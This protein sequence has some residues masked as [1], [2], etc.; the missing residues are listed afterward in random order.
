MQNMNQISLD[1]YQTLG[2]AV[3]VLFLGAFLKKR[4]KFLETFCI[5]SPVVGGLIFAIVSCILY[6]TGILEI[7]FDETLK[8]VCMVI[9]FTS[10]GFQANLKVLKSGGLS[11][12][13]F[14]VCV[15]VLII[16]QNLVSVGL[17]KLVGVSPL[18][19][20]STG[21][22]PMVGGHGTAGAFG[23]VLEDF[24]NLGCVNTLYS[25][26]NIRIGSR[27]TYGRTYWQTTYI[28]ARPFKNCRY[29]R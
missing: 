11:L 16:S 27:L 14:L 25:G 3:A 20:L 17:A 6:A 26:G 1:M 5:P 22:I 10:V 18:I 21:S 24:R 7:S 19:G 23:P 8:N 4:I 9:F 15:I 29:G 28:K 2:M 12:V 13:V